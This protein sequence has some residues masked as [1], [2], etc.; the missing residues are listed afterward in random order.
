MDG[1]VELLVGTYPSWSHLVVR[2]VLGAIFVAHGAQKLFG[3]F[4]GPGLRAT[5]GAFAAGFGIGAPATVAAALVETLGGVAMI[6]GLLAR[7]AAAGLAVVMLVAIVKVHAR[8]GFFLN[9]AMTPG[10]GHGVEYNLAL[11]AMALSIAIGG[12]GALSVD[13]WLV[14]LGLD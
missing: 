7:P 13:R 6:L 5:I 4:G 2:L 12:A 8:H 11:L 1:F 9:I 3:W 10:K 14:P